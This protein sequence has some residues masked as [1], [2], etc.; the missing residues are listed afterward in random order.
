[1]NKATLQAFSA[2]II[3]ATT[4]LSGS[5]YINHSN[6]EMAF[7]TSDAKKMLEAQGY[8]ISKGTSETRSG[9]TNTT[10]EPNSVTKQTIVTQSPKQEETP[11][12]E[13]PYILQVKSNMTAGQIAAVLEE[14]QIIDS[15]ITFKNYMKNKQL[16]RK[17]QIGEYPI[18]S[19]MDYEEIAQL[20]TQSQ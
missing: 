13:M 10:M 17:V 5:Y 18:S 3:F 1:M 15:A 16:T 8:S 2:G 12:K 14:E 11:Q 7:T 9:E 4:I 19:D 20:I 6:K